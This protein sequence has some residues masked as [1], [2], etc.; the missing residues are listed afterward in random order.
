M[1]A[2]LIDSIHDLCPN[3]KDLHDT[4]KCN[5]LL[6]SESPIVKHSDGP[7]VKVVAR[8]FYLAFL[9]H[10][11]VKDRVFM[12]YCYVYLSMSCLSDCLF[13]INKLVYVIVKIDNFHFKLS[14]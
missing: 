10:S 9:V 13:V 14:F 1:I 6:Y 12:S 4:H 2:F 3:L 5:Y 8:F 7:I 11:R